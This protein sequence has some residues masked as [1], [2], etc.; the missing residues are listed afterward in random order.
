MQAQERNLRPI[1]ISP[2]AASVPE[3]DAA[4]GTWAV[5]PDDSGLASG[6]NQR[7][8]G[9]RGGRAIAIMHLHAMKFDRAVLDLQAYGPKEAA[10]VPD[11]DD[12]VIERAVD[13]G[14]AERHPVRSAEGGEHCQ[15]YDNAGASQHR[16]DYTR[17]GGAGAASI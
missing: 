1:R 14:L 2:V 15:K 8:Y 11:L 5:K 7:C 17:I 3:L 6:T 10:A 9:H 13:V 12:V 4:D 16:S